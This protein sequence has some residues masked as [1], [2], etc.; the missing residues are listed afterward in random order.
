[1]GFR[2][3]EI[4]VVKRTKPGFACG[5]EQDRREKSQRLQFQRREITPAAAQI[6]WQ[7]TQNIDQLKTFAETD[8]VAEQ[9]RVFEFRAWKQMRAAYLGPELTHAAGDPIS[10]VI[11]FN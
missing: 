11:K 8:A 5:R 9:L 1:M 4:T 10:V 6:R 7:I 2:Q 3:I